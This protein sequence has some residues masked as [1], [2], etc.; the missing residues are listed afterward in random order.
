MLSC[1][2]FQ[3]YHD[4]I[5]FMLKTRLKYSKILKNHPKSLQFKKMTI[6][7]HYWKRF[8]QIFSWIISNVPDL[9]LK[10]HNK[11][12]FWEINRSIFFFRMSNMSKST[13]NSLKKSIKMTNWTIFKIIFFHFYLYSSVLSHNYFL[14]IKNPLCNVKK[15]IEHWKKYVFSLFLGGYFYQNCQLKRS[16]MGTI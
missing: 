11:S 7:T 4:R 3:I 9:L 12:I 1:N 16:R 14:H 6:S 2:F 10:C 8:F 13:K 15:N 5:T